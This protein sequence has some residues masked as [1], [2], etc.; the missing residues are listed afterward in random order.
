MTIWAK[1]RYL[2]CRY[3]MLA[4]WYIYIHTMKQC[5]GMK[6]YNIQVLVL[7]TNKPTHLHIPED[8]QWEDLLYPHLANQYTFYQQLPNIANQSWAN[9][10]PRIHSIGEQSTNSIINICKTTI[11]H[12]NHYILASLNLHVHNKH[13]EVHNLRLPWE[14]LLDVNLYPTCHAC[15]ASCRS[16]PQP[17]TNFTA[18]L[19]LLK[20]TQLCC[21]TFFLNSIINRKYSTI[22]LIPRK[23]FPSCSNLIQKSKCPPPGNCLQQHVMAEQSTHSALDSHDHVWVRILATCV[24]ERYT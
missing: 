7:L 24:L 20:L 5:Q 11:R 9:E 14:N 10:P 4:N 18:L 19:F 22:Q 13:V 16:L 17:L 2:A 23:P 6:T 8:S 12:C 3:I 1:H 21:F 15:Y